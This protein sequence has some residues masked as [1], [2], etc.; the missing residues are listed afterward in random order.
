MNVSL[1]RDR[2]FGKMFEKAKEKWPHASIGYLRL[3]NV[4]LV[5]SVIIILISLAYDIWVWSINRNEPFPI[6]FVSGIFDLIVL[7]SII[8]WF[9]AFRKIIAAKKDK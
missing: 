5:C 3:L 2:R 6:S 4:I 9:L 7:I 1:N 8:Y